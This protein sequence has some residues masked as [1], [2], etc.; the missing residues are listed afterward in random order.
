[1]PVEKELSPIARG[2]VEGLKRRLKDAFDKNPGI[3]AEEFA[4]DAVPHIAK[5]FTYLPEG[6]PDKMARALI[7]LA[8]QELKDEMHS[9]RSPE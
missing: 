6:E 3:T 5:L 4:A 7:A 9:A 2:L 1:M 8:V